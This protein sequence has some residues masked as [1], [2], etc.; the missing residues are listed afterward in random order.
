MGHQNT[1][2]VVKLIDLLTVL[3]SKLGP[4]ILATLA[5]YYV[6]ASILAATHEQSL[7]PAWLRMMTG[8][9][10]VR[11]FAFLFGMLGLAYGIK[12]RELRRASIERLRHRTEEQERLLDQHGILCSH[13]EPN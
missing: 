8:L 3:V 1:T 11:A 10:E 5:S 7:W 4:W 2:T 13:E 6:R 9:P 12:E